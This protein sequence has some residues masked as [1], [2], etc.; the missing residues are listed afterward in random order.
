MSETTFID[1]Y[2]LL[3][4]SPNAEMETIHRVFRMLAA[5]YHPDN[6]QS[7][8][9]ERFMLLNEAYNVLTDPQKRADYD[10]LYHAR[11]LEPLRVFNL[12][13]FALGIDGEANRRM[14]VLCLLYSRR[15][16]NPESS[17][18]SVLEFEN[19]MSLP[20]EHL[21]FTLWYLR[22]KGLIRQAEGSDFVITA[23]GVD[24]VEEHLPRNKVLYHLLKA[25]ESGKA[26]SASPEDFS[27]SSEADNQEGD[28]HS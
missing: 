22:E 17:G 16:S 2:E 12:R 14:G 8:D 24:W 7:G 11:R 25:A 6:P 10:I 4:I 27:P 18:M 3:Q 26:H 21:T 5:R 15:R 28:L 19:L 23:E 13:E 9:A 1:Y 20:R